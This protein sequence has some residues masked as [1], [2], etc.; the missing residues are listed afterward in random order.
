MVEIR[1]LNAGDL[2]AWARVGAQAYRRGD[3]G[4]GQPRWPEGEFTRYGLFDQGEQVAQFHLCHFEMFFDG[5][6]VPMGGVASV[7]CLPLARG[8]GYVEALLGHGLEQMRVQG[9]SFS[10]LHA[11]LVGLYRP[12]GWEWVGSRR[13]YTLPLAHLPAGL[14]TGNVRLAGPED[15]ETLRNLYE[16]HVARYRGTLARPLARWQQRLESTTGFTDY[17]YLYEDPTPAGYLHFTMRE[18]ARVRELIWQTPAAYQALLGVLRRH[19]SQLQEVLWDAPPDDPLWQ[20]AA[21]WDVK[22]AWV[23]PFSGR[24][25]DLPAALSLLRPAARVTGRCVVQVEDPL[26]VWNTGCWGIAVEGGSVTAARTS[27]TPHVACDIGVWS[28]LFFGD[29][30]ADALRRAGRLAVTDE[31]GF[32]LL[33]ALCPSALVWTNDGF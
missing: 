17:F 18:P 24:V 7:A 6:R 23:P 32:E 28:Q 2:P 30:A 5:R 20:H 8:K 4:D 27:A 25:V 13:S 26:A 3:Q 15:A 11:F 22:V 12:M 9:Q 1:E 21:H 10:A 14:D 19:R 31:R 29:P 33:Q 16:A